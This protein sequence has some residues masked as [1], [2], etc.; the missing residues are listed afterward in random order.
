MMCPTP[1]MD[2]VEGSTKVHPDDAVSLRARYG[3]WES[4]P[5]HCGG[6]WYVARVLGGNDEVGTIDDC[7]HYQAPAAFTPGLQRILV[8][9]TDWE[10]PNGCADCCS[11]ASIDLVPAP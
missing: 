9:A 7:G 5:G 6:L 1:E 2:V 8:E 3:D 11:Y 10:L 4:G